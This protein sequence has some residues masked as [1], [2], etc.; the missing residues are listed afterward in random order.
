MKANRY[1][2]Q[3]SRWIKS[4]KEATSLL[5]KAHGSDAKVVLYP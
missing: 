1:Y 2:G 4:L 3:G 5:D